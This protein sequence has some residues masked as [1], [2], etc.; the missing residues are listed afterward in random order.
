M[1]AESLRALSAE[2]REH[3]EARRRV[4]SIRSSR[5]WPLL[6]VSYKVMHALRAFRARLGRAP[7]ASPRDGDVD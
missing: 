2:Q 3:A 6:I 1:V 4:E 5:A 7:G